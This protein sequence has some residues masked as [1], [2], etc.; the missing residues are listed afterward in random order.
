MLKLSWRVLRPYS[1]TLTESPVAEA[2]AA[3]AH[4]QRW[5]WTML[6]KYSHIRFAVIVTIVSRESGVEIAIV[7]LR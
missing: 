6:W 3:A 7:S 1:G 2:K 4:V 5:K